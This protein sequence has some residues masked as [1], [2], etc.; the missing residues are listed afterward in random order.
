MDVFGK[1]AQIITEIK[2]VN[3]IIKKKYNKEN[4]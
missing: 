1:A 4:V 2:K 3:S